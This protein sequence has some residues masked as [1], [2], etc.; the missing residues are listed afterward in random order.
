MGIGGVAVPQD[1]IQQ[2]PDYASALAA[3]E[4]LPPV[5]VLFDNG[6]GSTPGHPVPGFE[7]SFE[8]FPPPGTKAKSLYLS[9]EGALT[10]KSGGS[11]ADRFTWNPAARSA[12]DFTGNTGSGTGGLWTATPPYHWEQSPAGTAAS[13]VTSPLSKDTAVLGSGAL[14]LWVRSSARNVDLQAT[15]SEVRPDGKETFVQGGWLRTEA[16]VLDEERSTLLQ[17]VP[18]YARRDVTKLPKG[19]WTKVSVPLYYQG[20]VYR[21][22]SSIRVTVQAPGGDQP[23][24]AFAE[25]DPAG[26]TP[27]VAIAH[28]K[29]QPS[30]LVLP[31]SNAIE[32]PTELPPCPSLRGQPC[33][34][35]V[36]FANSPFK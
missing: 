34:D 14:E 31:V 25:A 1:P 21:Q 9:N 17:P 29:K 26:Q 36:P 16:R 3:F 28:S 10:A 8:N 23:V 32:A 7:Q 4:A 20:H 15:V 5:R 33:R 11:G 12:T 6:A 2:T 19:K 35:Y 22:G 27:W 30:R 13:Y 18:T 24:W